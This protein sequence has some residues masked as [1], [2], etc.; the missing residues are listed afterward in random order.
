M[1]SHEGL[2]KLRDMQNVASEKPVEAS[3]KRKLQRGWTEQQSNQ[4]EW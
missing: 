3:L 1:V 2:K 4:M